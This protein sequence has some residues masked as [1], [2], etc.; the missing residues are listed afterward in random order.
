MANGPSTIEQLTREAASG[1]HELWRTNWFAAEGIGAPR[2]KN[3]GVPLVDVPTGPDHSCWVDE[4]TQDVRI[5]I[6]ARTF[7]QLTPLWQHENYAAATVV[8]GALLG[9]SLRTVEELGH[10][11]HTAW[12]D[13]NGTYASAVQLQPYGDLPWSEQRK[14]LVQV[15]VAAGV[16]LAANE[17]SLELRSR[18]SE[19]STL[20]R[21]ALAAGD[22]IGQ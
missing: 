16:V 6:A 20:V 11:I 19:L 10:V 3:A 15:L 18:V 12:L 22:A 13:R 4:E 21:E 2:P 14:D 7:A 8:I 1:L 9:T 5:D 17:S